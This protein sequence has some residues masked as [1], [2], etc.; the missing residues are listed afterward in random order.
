MWGWM[1]FEHC[2]TVSNGKLVS[3]KA[4]WLGLL[5]RCTIHNLTSAHINANPATK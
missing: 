5:T 1:S 2:E 3:L 4:V